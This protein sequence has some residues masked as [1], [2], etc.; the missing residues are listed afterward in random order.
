MK[1][2]KTKKTPNAGA[3]RLTWSLGLGHL[4]KNIPN[5]SITALYRTNT[6]SS[7]FT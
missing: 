6:C 3:E 1:D 2:L 4:L 7:V 5:S